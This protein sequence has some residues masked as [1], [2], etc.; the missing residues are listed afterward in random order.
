G[1]V[2]TGCG[3]GP[4]GTRG[5]RVG[6]LYELEP[7][8]KEKGAQKL[9]FIVKSDTIVTKSP[10]GPNA[11]KP[12]SSFPISLTSGLQK[13]LD[14]PPRSSVQ[15]R[16]ISDF[17]SVMLDTVEIYIKD[18]NFSRDSQWSLASEMVGSCCYVDQ[19]VTFMG[20]RI[21]SVQ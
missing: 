17:K 6:E 15:V 16:H 21:G 11:G 1:F 8:R 7:I 3:F 2:C 10:A 9:I 4:R 20:T 19:R 13:L 14:V 5:A 18:V 12:K